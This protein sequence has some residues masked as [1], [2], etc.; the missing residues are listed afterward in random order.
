MS[1]EPEWVK[2]EGD[3]FLSVHSELVAVVT[4][5]PSDANKE[6]TFGQMAAKSIQL[7]DEATTLHSQL[8]MFC[9]SQATDIW[10]SFCVTCTSSPC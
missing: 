3:S 6:H 2:D 1:A 7:Q 10:R 9:K 8:S 5:A 4:Q